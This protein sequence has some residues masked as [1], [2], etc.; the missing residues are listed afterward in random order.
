[1]GATH[2]LILVLWL[3]A[4]VRL[5]SLPYQVRLRTFRQMMCTAN[6]RNSKKFKPIRSTWSWSIVEWI[7]SLITCGGIRVSITP[8]MASLVMALRACTTH[9]IKYALV[10]PIQILWHKKFQMCHTPW[11]QLI[12]SSW[13]SG[14]LQESE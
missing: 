13:P 11:G 2:K 7:R 3:P 12:N 14:Y 5:T 1:M 10:C 4:G 9:N 8:L 6:H